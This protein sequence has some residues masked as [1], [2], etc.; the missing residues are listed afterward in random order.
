MG[1]GGGLIPKEGFSVCGLWMSGCAL[2]TSTVFSILLIALGIALTAVGFS[3]RADRRLFGL[4]DTQDNYY[5]N[6]DNGRVDP[7][8][9]IGPIILGVGVFFAVV[10]GVLCILASKGDSSYKKGH[11]SVAPSIDSTSTKKSSSTG[12][13]TGV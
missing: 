5:T 7:L 13:S 10:F 1:A 6:Q 8:Q 2:C 3:D 12:K 9:L 4:E 11:Y